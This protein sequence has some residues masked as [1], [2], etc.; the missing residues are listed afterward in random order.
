MLGVLFVSIC[1]NLAAK[2]YHFVI[3]AKI[4][5]TFLALKTGLSDTLLDFRS[6][7]LHFEIFQPISLP[8]SLHIVILHKN[9]GRC[10]RTQRPSSYI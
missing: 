5:L 6:F 2:V 3:T 9:E 8:Y 7:P 1:T 4:L 10:V